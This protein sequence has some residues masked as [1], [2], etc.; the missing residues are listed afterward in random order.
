MVGCVFFEGVEGPVQTLAEFRAGEQTPA[1]LAG[2]YLV[3]VTDTASICLNGNTGECRFAPTGSDTSA[4]AAADLELLLTF[5][6]RLRTALF[7]VSADTPD[8]E[9]DRVEER[10]V[11]HYRAADPAV[12]EAD[13]RWIIRRCIGEVRL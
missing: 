9:L 2:D 13:W 6:C 11:A 8:D 5:L 7:D 4:H 10:L 1:E 12:A 3:A